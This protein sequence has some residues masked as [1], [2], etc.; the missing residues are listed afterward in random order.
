MNNK[1]KWYFHIDKS[2]SI[3]HIFALLDTVETDNEDETHELMNDSD[4]EFIAPEDI[5]LTDNPDTASVLTQGTNV[6]LVDEGSTHTKE[7]EA[8]KKRK[9]SEQN[10]PIA[11]KGNFFPHSWQNCLLEGG[12]SY[13]FYDS[14]SAFDIYQQAI[15]FDVFTELVVQQSNFYL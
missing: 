9:K 3:V 7:L 10:T 13:Q 12:V 14:A 1:Q 5:K 6:H 2:T 4:T 15:N 11:W 8:N